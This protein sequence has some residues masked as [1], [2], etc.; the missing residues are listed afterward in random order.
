VVSQAGLALTTRR[1]GRRGNARRSARTKRSS[2]SDKTSRGQKWSEC[3]THIICPW[4]GWEFNLKTGRH[5][6][7][8]HMRLRAFD[9]TVKDDEVYIVV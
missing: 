9:V 1:V 3:D 6:G 8:P 4:H 5:P 2:L 7:N